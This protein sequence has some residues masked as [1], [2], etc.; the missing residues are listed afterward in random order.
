MTEQ[1]SVTRE[2][3]APA[4][5]VWTMVADVTR[6][7]EWSPE[8]ESATWLR[9]ATGPEPGSK[10]R[11][12]NRNGSRKWNTVATVIAAEPGR[13]FTFCVTKGAL[14][15]AEWRYELEPTAT[16]CRITETWI[17]RRGRIATML[18]GPVSGVA[19][20]ASHNREGMEQTLDSLKRAAEASP[21]KA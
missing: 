6:M 1:V 4:E 12:Y 9:G 17:D 14:K 8:H 18:G 5:H 19:D 7:A 15:I 2:I 16:G 21:A 10:F 11:G 13:R 20:R 3:S